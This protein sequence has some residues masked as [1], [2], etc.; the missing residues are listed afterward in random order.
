MPAIAPKRQV[1]VLIRRLAFQVHHAARSEDPDS[2]HDL[3]V[4]IR[5]FV[6]GLRTFRDSF[7]AGQARKI[8]RRLKSVMKASAEVRNRDITI[9]FLNEY[10]ARPPVCAVLEQERTAAFARLSEELMVMERR[11]FSSRWRDRLGLAVRS[12]AAPPNAYKPLQ[13]L[14]DKFFRAGRKA[15]GGEADP[16]A[17]HRL[18][19]RA[20][21]L[22]YT[23]EQLGAAFGPGLDRKIEQ[24]RGLQQHLGE[25]SDCA[26][27]RGLLH[28]RKGVPS[29][30]PQRLGTRLKHAIAKLRKYWTDTF[31]APGEQDR[32]LR[33][34]NR[35]LIARPAVRAARVLTPSKLL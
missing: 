4:S 27:I 19:L 2:V 9:E 16:A 8:R 31:D 34:L 13:P 3:R 20:K 32:W 21:R 30:V 6:Q 22:R 17:L 5:R 15:I 28:G 7:P 10:R 1:A 29:S 25:I 35:H 24:L 33:Y 11:G 14:V 26:T 23:L 12:A 18:R